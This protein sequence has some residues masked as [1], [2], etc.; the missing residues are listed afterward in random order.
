[1][2]LPFWK[3]KQ[4][5]REL[6]EEIQAHL[7]LGA[8][9]E[10]E[11]GRSRTEAE[12]AAR[13]TFGNE[14]LT[15]EITRDIWG[16]RWIADLLQDIRYGLRL[17]AKNR[18]FTAIAILVLTLGIGL[19]TA[20]FTAY[21]AMVARQIEARDP[22][23]MVNLALVRESGAADFQF[24]YPDYEAYRDSM[25]SFSGVIALATN[26]LRLSVP[27][28]MSGF[29]TPA[30]DSKIGKSGLSPVGNAE[31]VSVFVIS[32]NYFQV[33]GATVLAGRT[34]DSFSVPQLLASPSVLISE[35][36][37]Q[38]RFS[39]D[40]EILGKTIYLNGSPVTVVGITPHDFVGTQ[41]SA[42]DF[43]LPLGLAP[44][45]HADE[46]WLGNRENHCCR[47][48]ARL[49]PG[50]SIAQAKSEMNVL[51]DH[52]R[53]LNGPDS[54][55]AK[56]ATAL[57]WPASPFPLP[58]KLYAGLSSA[59]LLIMAAA[60]MVLAVSCADVGSLQL[61]RI[62]SRE[63]ELRT[64]L[65]LGASRL[66]IIRQ[67]L[68]ES[69][70]LGLFAGAL[71]FLFSWSLLR[72]SAVLAANAVPLEYGTLI[73]NV[74]PDFAI[75]AYVFAIS[76][77]SGILFGLAPALES[78]SSALTGAVRGST[79]SM[80]NRRTQEFLIAVQV[81]LSLALMIAGTML[82]RSSI[83]S[84]KMETGY[85]TKHV[86]DVELKFPE[87][88]KYTP[89]R[90]LA[91]VREIRTRIS[92]LPEV[93][94]V[95][96]ARLS[97]EDGLLTPAQL[98]DSSKSSTQPVSSIHYV[99]VQPNY[100]QTLG[101]PVL[102]GHGFELHTSQLERTIVIS[103]SEAREISPR[104]NPIGRT[105]RLGLVD[106]LFHDPRDLRADGPTYQIIGVARDV[107][108]TDLNSDDSRQLYLSMPEDKVHSHP[109]L[110]RVSSGASQVIRTIDP[111]IA[112]V[113]PDLV[114]TS[115]TLDDRLRQS[116]S[117]IVSSIAAAIA[118]GVGLLGFLPALM[119][120][121]GTVSYVVV[122][123][124]RE[125]GIRMALGAF[126][127]D[128]LALILR[129]S[130]RS[131]LVGLLA[132]IFLAI[133]ASYMVRSVLLGIR[134]VDPISFVGVSFSFL[135]IALLAA[136][137]PARRATKVDPIAALR[138]E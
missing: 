62:R 59:I 131:V 107:R 99:Y 31:F 81:A 30:S 86:I 119:G 60:G 25:R 125:I 41:I 35:N 54:A 82:I 130:A 127:R 17:L 68:T 33:L 84:L 53:G 118:S 134:T 21:K 104:Q 36:Y 83:N 120:I 92:A 65:A 45:V 101:I 109:I 52:L 117:F 16:W 87:S 100:F 111:I 9:E 61:A 69:V 72:V 10:M 123:R 113:D 18:G 55:S 93:V 47:L 29:G 112:S 32:E 27:A 128:I 77:V 98:I 135:T 105:I 64:R 44:V 1:M 106:E 11:V 15:R 26:S 19:N 71:A 108:R 85:E 22:G 129:E 23:K 136:L 122:L 94:D 138:N 76:L 48:F 6:D 96:I 66:R 38:K 40:P 70:V 75:F 124:T 132:G 88:L 63:N 20:V 126:R 89:A 97:G 28:A 110:V 37:W 2:K 50:V 57:V 67:L 79:S 4:R 8:H 137:L 80:R 58:L 34:F 43:W 13:R 12:L 24:N 73:F 78:S 90:K 91:L 74:N 102:V 56:R 116:P 114:Q 49:A 5:D 3:R 103:E 95:T 42:P 133:G 14:A 7:T 46:H 39:R 51:A 115:I 121:Y